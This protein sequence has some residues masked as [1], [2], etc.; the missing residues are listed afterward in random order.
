MVDTKEVQPEVIASPRLPYLPC[1]LKQPSWDV[2]MLL[3]RLVH[4]INTQETVPGGYSHASHR[5]DSSP[6]PVLASR[7]PATL[8]TLHKLVRGLASL[9]FFHTKWQCSVQAVPES[10]L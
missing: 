2:A 8:R 4:S 3:A 10:A 1:T 7:R 9:S 6:G 5:T